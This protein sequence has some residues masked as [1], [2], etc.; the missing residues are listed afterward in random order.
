MEILRH[1][2]K[3]FSCA[4]RR[5]QISNL[6]PH[7]LTSHLEVRRPNTLSDLAVDLL[8]SITDFLP[9]E[10]ICCLSLCDRRLF[11][12][13]GGRGKTCNCKPVIGPK[14]IIQSISRVTPAMLFTDMIAHQRALDYQGR[15]INKCPSQNSAMRKRKAGGVPLS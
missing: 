2:A 1:F 10:D 6:E 8:L 3:G 4:G 13:L 11:T 7:R 14:S 15:S 12:A 5:D 9:P